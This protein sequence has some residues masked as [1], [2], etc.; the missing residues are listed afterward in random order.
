MDSKARQR[1]HPTAGGL[2]LVLLAIFSFGQ[3]V[4]SNKGGQPNVDPVA[5]PTLTAIELRELMTK[6]NSGDAKAELQLGQAYRHGNGVPKNEESAFKW[7]QKAAER[8][9]ADAENDLGTMYRLGEGVARDK[10]EAFRWYQKA[11]RHGSAV[12]MFNLGTCH[13]NGDGVNSNE[14]TA[15]LWFILAQEAGDP[16][17]ND[18]VRR[19]E[20]SMEK[21]DRADAYYN[22]AK[23]YHKGE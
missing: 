22:I 21:S 19:S 17:A 15:Y 18:A 14:Y 5:R 4:D 12:G 10:G 1:G 2:L 13:Y 8:G 7:I 16:I 11:A 6:A 23:M 9:D 3:N 20:A